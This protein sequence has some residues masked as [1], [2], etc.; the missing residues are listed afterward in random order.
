MLAEPLVDLP[1]LFN[2][3]NH[4]ELLD[5]NHSKAHTFKEE[6]EGETMQIDAQKKR[7]G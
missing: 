4:Q 2:I 3:A 5:C 6:W 7:T 1:F